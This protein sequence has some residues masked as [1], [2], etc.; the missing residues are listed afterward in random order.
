MF[1]LPRMDSHACTTLTSTREHPPT[2][3]CD[4][5]KSQH[6][7][8]K[9]ITAS[10]TPRTCHPLARLPQQTDVHFSQLTFLPS[11][12]HNLTPNVKLTP[13]P[14][15][16]TQ[17][18]HTHKTHNINILQFNIRIWHLTQIRTAKT[19]I[20]HKQLSHTLIPE[21]KLNN[22]HSTAT[23]EDYI[24]IRAWMLIHFVD[25]AHA[26]FSF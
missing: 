18:S 25:H 22:T 24:C 23:I 20:A 7:H 11:P 1:N 4:R 16:N 26:Y 21:T 6:L 9:S 13:P 17:Q 14:Q 3:T 15:A 8:A 5:C 2:W 10:Q 12:C 19:L